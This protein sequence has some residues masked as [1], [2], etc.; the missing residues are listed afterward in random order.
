MRGG[1]GGGR[2]A[3]VLLLLLCAH[4][5]SLE[6]LFPEGEVNIRS[7]GFL[8]RFLDVSSCYIGS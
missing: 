5:I 4:F 8:A 2:V 3:R 1:S 6:V 7:G